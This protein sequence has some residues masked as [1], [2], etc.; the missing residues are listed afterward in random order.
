MNMARV[1]HLNT[2]TG[3]LMLVL[4]TYFS[5]DGGLTDAQRH[6]LALYFQSNPAARSSLYPL[7]CRY[8]PRARICRGVFAKRSVDEDD[9]SMSTEPTKLEDLK[10]EGKPFIPLEILKKSQKAAKQKEDSAE[11]VT[12]YNA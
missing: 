10:A 8:F 1:L 12:P 6:K 3:L 11:I 2:L 9:F 4:I 7:D 5:V